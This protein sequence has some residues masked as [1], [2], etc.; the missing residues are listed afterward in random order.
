MEVPMSRFFSRRH[1][2]GA[3]GVLAVSPLLGPMPLAGAA[4]PA[5]RDRTT[6]GPLSAYLPPVRVFDSR[7]HVAPLNG[8]KLQPGESVAVTV[9]ADFG[10]GTFA[11]AVLVNCTVTQTEVSGY[12]VIRG[13]DLSGERPL[14]TT[15]NINWYAP[16]QTLA[17]LTFTDVG[18]ENALEVH[19]GGPGA[20][21][22]IIDVQGF[23]PINFTA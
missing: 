3:G 16:N 15:S 6:P 7:Q 12:L 22:F 2:L 11:V 23:V 9:P 21:H 17:N 13:S 8:A 10:D 14:P 20:T 4:A 1:L 5:L 19:N 18:G